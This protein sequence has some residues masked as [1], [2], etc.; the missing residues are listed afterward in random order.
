MSKDIGYCGNHC[1]YCFFTEWDGC[2]SNN[3]CCSYANLFGDKKCP[4]VVCCECKSIDGCWQCG[5]V[6]YCQTGFF[7]SGKNDAKA[8]ALYIKEYGTEQYTKRIFELIRKG[9]DYPRYFKD[10]NDVEKILGI[11]ENK[12]T[13]SDKHK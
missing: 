11:F 1:E 13:Q 8:Y 10:V 2:K 9:Y 7:S 4:N 12:V 3:P 5:N 6:A